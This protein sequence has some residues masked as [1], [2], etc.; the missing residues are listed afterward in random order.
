MMII[1]SFC[2]NPN[3]SQK[4]FLVHMY[5]FALSC[6]YAKRSGFNIRLHCDKETNEVLKYCPYD[7]IVVD[8]DPK[9]CPHSCIY[10]WPKFKAMQNEDVGNIHI[11]GDVFLKSPGLKDILNYKEY[12]CIVQ[13]KE[14]YSPRFRLWTDTKNLCNKL[15]YPDF[16]KPQLLEMYNCGTVGISNKELK[17]EYFKIYWQCI[18]YL[19]TKLTPDNSRDIFELHII[20]DIVYEQQV[21]QDLCELKNYKTKFIIPSATKADLIDY[22]NQIGYQHVL[23]GKYKEM[24]LHFCKQILQMLNPKIFNKLE[25]IFKDV[26]L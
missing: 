23:G 12:D 3:C 25:E 24:N 22:A 2:K 21:L 14:E 20:P 11:D 15:I 13:G 7:E 1:H 4:S 5:Y 16:L 26:Q 19:S 10:A 9:D 8:L 6:V 18:N 17:D